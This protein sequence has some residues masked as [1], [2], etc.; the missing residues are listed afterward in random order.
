MNRRAFMSGALSVVAAPLAGEAQQAGKVYRIGWL[1]TTPASPAV[2]SRHPLVQALRDYGF[3]EGQN[4]IFELR[5]S[6]GIE[7][8]HAGLVA[9]LIRMKVDI[10][11]TGNSAA[12]RAAKQ[13]TST[14][15][16]VMLGVASPERQGLIAS[17]ARPGGNVTGMSNELGGEVS[18]KMFQLLNEMLPQ[19][20][21]VAIMWNPDNS[22][23]AT[24]FKE[25]EVPA[26]KS[27]GVALVSL[28]I[29][30]PEDV[31]RA[32]TA[33]TSARPDA[34]LAHLVM[35]PF[36][37]RFL[38][39]VAKIRIPIVGQASLWPQVGG[40]MSFGPDPADLSRRAATYVVKL[41][42]GANAADLPVEQPTKFELVINMRTAKAL[43]LTIP[44]SL[45]LRADQVI[46]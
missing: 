39:F 40:L 19:L 45:L 43:G 38:E 24:T 20:S 10:I 32:L 31:D 27:V 15:P 2:M 9:E 23:S 14:T 4:V 5:Y 3:V 17:L 13:A 1:A 25:V 21:K 18:G 35:F 33:L 44:P 22:G 28:E 6:E 30:R 12:V 11:V 29:R 7:E 37:A 26:A 16:I 42:R 41:L 46:E 34:V 8:R 36:R